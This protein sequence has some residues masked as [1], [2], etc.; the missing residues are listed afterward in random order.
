MPSQQSSFSGLPDKSIV[1]GTLIEQAIELVW[2]S[3]LPWR[4]HPDRPLVEGE[5]ELNGYL[6]DYLNIRKH[7]MIRFQ[8]EQRQ[9]GRHR[10]DI[11]AKPCKSTVIFG[12][13]YTIFQPICAIECKRLPAPTKDREWEYVTGENG[14][15]SG[16]IQR[17]KLGAHGKEHDTA[18]MVGYVQKKSP[19][20]WH[21]LVNDW[22][23]ELA[24]NQ[25][26][27]WSE[28]EKLS[29][30]QCFDSGQRVKSFSVHSR[31]N[32]CKSK[33]IGIHHFWIQMN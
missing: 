31:V 33:A 15:A 13:S 26:D 29:K 27:S 18:V 25:P 1:C 23:S 2:D 9:K 16:G 22:I 7:P 8:H 5:E 12:V 6:C 21:P 19:K 11:A 4:D 32:E 20:D 30:M 24:K 14:K 3:L 10:V 17:Y 28:N